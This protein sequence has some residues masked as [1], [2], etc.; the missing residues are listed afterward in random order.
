MEL[1]YKKDFREGLCRQLDAK[2]SSK[3]SLC[4]FES[5]QPYILTLKEVRERKLKKKEEKL[6]E[7]DILLKD[8]TVDSL[9]RVLTKVPSLSDWELRKEKIL[10]CGI[11]LMVFG[12]VGKVTQVTGFSKRIIENTI[13]RF[14]NE[15]KGKI[16]RRKSCSKK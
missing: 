15:F 2:L 10:T 1:S 11:D 9:G 14:P 13:K 5:R 6:K 8:C 16:F 4:G 12:W 7:R 3:Q